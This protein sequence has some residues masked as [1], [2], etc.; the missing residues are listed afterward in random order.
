MNKTKQ[1]SIRVN[2]TLRDRFNEHCEKNGYSV[3]KRLRTLIEND[4]KKTNNAQL[5]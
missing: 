5:K 3:S 1:M 4:I 2:Q